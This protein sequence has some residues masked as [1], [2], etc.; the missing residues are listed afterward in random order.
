MI[1]N[2]SLQV[3]NSNKVLVDHLCQEWKKMCNT[4]VCI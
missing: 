1:K 2:D 3:A 4:K